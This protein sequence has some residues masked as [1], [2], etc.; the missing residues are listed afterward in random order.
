MWQP[1]HNG[2]LSSSLDTYN[3]LNQSSSQHTMVVYILNFA[4]ENFYI[5]I[6]LLNFVVATHNWFFIFNLL[7]HLNVKCSRKMAG[8]T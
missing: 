7:I 5:V 8:Q 3:L 1:P 6:L 4:Y 2:A